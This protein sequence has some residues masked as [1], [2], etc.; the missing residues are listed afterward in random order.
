MRRALAALLGASALVVAGCGYEGTV[1]PTAK[2]V[3]GT[4]PTEQ[5]TTLPKGDATAGKKLFTTKGCAGC[6][7]YGPAGSNGKVGP[8]LD[9]LPEYA[10]K[11]GQGPLDQFVANSILNPSSYVESGYSD[12]MPKNY[13]NLPKKQLSDLVTFL[14]QKQ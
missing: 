2:D 13:A 8:D 3:S 12:L 7:T 4:L 1:Q 6:H 10:Q 9:K 5:K 14:T 11:A